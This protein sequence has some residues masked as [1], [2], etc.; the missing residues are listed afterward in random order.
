VGLL[1]VFVGGL[2]GLGILFEKLTGMHDEDD[3]EEEEN[4][5]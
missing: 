4:D 1:D 3:D 5:P 2:E